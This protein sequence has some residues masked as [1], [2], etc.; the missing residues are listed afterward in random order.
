MRGRSGRIHPPCLVDSTPPIRLIGGPKPRGSEARPGKGKTIATTQDDDTK[1]RFSRI[2]GVLELLAPH[3]AGLTVTEVSQQL[4]LPLSSTHNLLQRLVKA[5]AVIVTGDL[6]YS[7]GGRAVRYGIRIMEGL[8]LRGVARRHLQDLAAL[9]GEDV[10]LAERFGDKIV[11]TDRVAGHRPVKLDIRLGQSLLLHA[12][13]VG[14]LF[15]AHHP[16]L[17]TLMLDR[18]RPELTPKTVVHEDDLQREL[19][20]IRERGYSVSREEAV[21]GI[22]GL[23]VPVRDA[24]SRVVAAL[25]LSALAAHWDPTVEKEWLRRTL[26]AAQAVERNLGR[27]HGDVDD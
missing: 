16:E 10:Y 26:D 23:A 1:D 24:S 11:Y 9:L 4:G 21:I 7:I 13:S 6:R 8:N 3:P 18:E 2:F 17:R 20:V 15:T 27:L 19:K 14:K 22:V 12:T 5:E 25:H